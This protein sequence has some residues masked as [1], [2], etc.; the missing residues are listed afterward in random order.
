MG[1]KQSVVQ[2]QRRWRERE[3]REAL[4]ELAS[5]GESA[6]SFARHHGIST[7][8]LAYWKKR[9]A[10]ETG[11]K[12]VAVALPPATSPSWIE[13]AAAGVVVRIREQVDVDH[14]A[15]LVEAIGRRMGTPC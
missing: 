14:V 1:T 10:P 4:T 2:V 3:A 9:L 11:P 7:Q 5:S 8:R 6:A 13:I 12:F 15:R